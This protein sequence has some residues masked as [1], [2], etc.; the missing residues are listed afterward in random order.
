MLQ[1][2]FALLAGALEVHSR[3]K[4]TTPSAPCHFD[5]FHTIGMLRL[6]SGGHCDESKEAWQ[7][8][9]ADRSWEQHLDLMK[10]GMGGTFG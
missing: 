7:W 10:V 8:M 4:S 9:I 6:P 3:E 1:T 5:P 2:N